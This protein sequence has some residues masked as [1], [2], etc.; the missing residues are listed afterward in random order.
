MSSLPNMI[1]SL[2]HK[3]QISAEQCDELLNKLKGHDE[4]LLS[5]AVNVVRCC[6]CKFY[7]KV[8]GIYRCQI[9]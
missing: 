1:K 8:D 6:E 2:R 5:N 7:E 9:W 3:G 4:H